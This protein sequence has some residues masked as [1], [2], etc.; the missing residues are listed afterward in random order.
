MTEPLALFDAEQTLEA[1]RAGRYAEYPAYKP[2][3]VEWLGDVPEHWKT[4]QIRRL[5]RTI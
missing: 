5:F 3:G 4:L 2:S 1:V